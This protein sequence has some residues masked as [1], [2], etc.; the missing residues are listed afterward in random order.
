MPSKILSFNDFEKV[1]ESEN[2]LIAEEDV[3]APPK[4]SAENSVIDPSSGDITEDPKEILDLMKELGGGA[5][6]EGEEAPEEEKDP[7]ESLQEQATAAPVNTLKVAKMGETSDRVKEIQKTLG[8]EPSGK[9]DQATKDA[10]VAFQKEQKK[11]NPKTVVDGIVGPQTYGLLLK[12]KKGITDAAEIAK[13]LDAFKNGGKMVIDIKK[14]GS[15]IALDPKY[16]DIFESIEVVTVNGTSYVV[17]TPKA[18][19]ALKVADLKAAGLIKA[20]FEWILSVPL[21]VGKA[22]VYTAIGVVVVTVE[23]AK[24][25][26]NAAIS[27]TSW[28]GKK[29]MASSVVHGLGQI[30]KWVGTTSAAAWAKV[31][32]G[33]A[34]VKALWNGFITNTVAMVAKKKEALL[35]L[36]AACSKSLSSIAQDLRTAVH[37]KMIAAGKELQLAWEKTKN[38]GEMV[39]AGFAADL[40]KAK[41]IA[42][43]IQKSY[44]DAVAR[45]NAIGAAVG[46]GLQS[47]GKGVVKVIGD[48]VQFAGQKIKDAGAWISSLAEALE[49]PDGV[50]MLEWLDY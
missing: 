27:V 48:G 41:E 32:S 25:M 35:A 47:A 22:L 20:G 43:N 13:Q 24:A 9:F 31:K 16:Y 44:N 17:A 29:I 8:L 36:A 21:F 37:Q 2:Y 39:K 30:C 12:I 23:V 4:D 49:T 10:V 5:P 28:A 11:K 38:L 26:V 19:A 7:N 45:T 1:Y 6:A 18:D 34:E 42:S 50:L 3:A 33:A 46:S 40:V 15:N 14:A